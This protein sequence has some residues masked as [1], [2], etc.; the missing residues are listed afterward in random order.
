MNLQL[1]LEF[2]T[3]VKNL[4]FRTRHLKLLSY[5][6]RGQTP[7]FHQAHNWVKFLSNNKLLCIC[8]KLGILVEASFASKILCRVA[9]RH[10]PPRHQGVN[11][12]FNSPG[13]SNETGVISVF[14]DIENCPIPRGKSG[15]DFVKLVRTMLYE[16]R[17]E[18]SFSVVCDVHNLNNAQTEELS[19]SNVTICHMSNTNKN[20]ADTK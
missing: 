20:A 19:A 17:I 2:S 5:S 14:W 11:Y 9:E 13:T 8:S 15:V 4:M 10:F 6:G 7:N 1:K 3:V 16:N 12:R 18:G